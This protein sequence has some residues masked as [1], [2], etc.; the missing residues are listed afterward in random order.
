MFDLLQLLAYLGAFWLFVFSP[1]FRAKWLAEYRAAS[2]GGRVMR[3]LEGAVATLCGLAP[4]AVGA[5]L[6]IP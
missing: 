5:W 3:L 2:T 6:A 4:F 1:G